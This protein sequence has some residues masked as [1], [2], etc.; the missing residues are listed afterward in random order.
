MHASERLFDI[1]FFM[2][3][4][5]KSISTLEKNILFNLSVLLTRTRL[6]SS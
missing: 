6:A 3:A 2:S 4:N 1:S 5:Q